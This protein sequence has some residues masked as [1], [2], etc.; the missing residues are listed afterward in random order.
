MSSTTSASAI[1]AAVAPIAPTMDEKHADAAKF[2]TPKKAASPAKP[3]VDL[4]IGV[5]PATPIQIDAAQVAPGAPVKKQPAPTAQAGPLGHLE[6]EDVETFPKGKIELTIE[7]LLKCDK[8]LPPNI[9]QFLEEKRQ[10]LYDTRLANQQ[11]AIEAAHKINAGRLAHYTVAKFK[12]YPE[13]F[14]AGKMLCFYDASAALDGK[15]TIHPIFE[16]A[17][18]A[19]AKSLGEDGD[20]ILKGLRIGAK[21]AKRFRPLV[22]VAKPVSPAASAPAPA[23]AVLSATTAN[24]TAL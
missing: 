4:S 8:E 12:K 18:K 3:A 21:S 9:R 10:K 1:A 5:A 6:F 2:V 15:M 14:E 19:E 22:T 16:A 20:A 7:S 11:L 17:V 13:R 23:S 24:T